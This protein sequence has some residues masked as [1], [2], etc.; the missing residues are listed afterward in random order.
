MTHIE[1]AALGWDKK[2]WMK[3]LE[4][5][6][7]ENRDMAFPMIHMGQLEAN[8]VGQLLAAHPNI[9]FMTSHSNTISV[10][11]SHQPWINM[12]S[13]Q[14]LKSEWVELILLY[15]ERFILNFDNMFED[16]WG[17]FYLDQVIL[18]RK[19]LQ[20]LPGDVAHA[21]AHNNAEHLWRL[22]SATLNSIT[23]LER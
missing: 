18:W 14:T 7:S 16:H 10:R 6:L 11:A 5:L 17:Q 9:Y 2:D 20:A 23:R 22:P 13:D 19:A 8:D 21:I 3:H 1:F 4:T 15:P 12:F